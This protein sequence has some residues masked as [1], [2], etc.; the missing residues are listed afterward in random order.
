M[1]RPRQPILMSLILLLSTHAHAVTAKQPDAFP[2]PPLPITKDFRWGLMDRTGKVL[3]EPKYVRFGTPTEGL[4]WFTEKFEGPVGYMDYE[5]TIVIS[6]RYGMAHEFSDGYA[7][8]SDSGRP[9]ND[10][11]GVL[12][13]TYGVIDKTGAFVIEAKY[14][15][16]G[17]PFYKG[18][19]VVDALDRNYSQDVI[20]AQGR[21]HGTLQN[22][23][24]LRLTR[25]SEDFMPVKYFVV[26]A[27]RTG[28]ATRT[29]YG[30][31]D[32]RFRAV[33]VRFAK[34]RPFSDG[35]A[36]VQQANN[37]QWG[38][39]NKT[40]RYAIQ[41][42][43]DYATEFSEGVAAVSLSGD[44]GDPQ[45]GR[46]YQK[47]KWGYVDAKGRPAVAAPKGFRA[48]PFRGGVAPILLTNEGRGRDWDIYGD[49]IIINRVGETVFKL[50]HASMDP[51]EDGLALVRV[52]EK[53]F[54]C[55]VG[56]IDATGKWIREPV[57]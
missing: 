33:F 48:A 31:V 4:I 53:P 56:Y 52:Y 18:L 11:T 20:D 35:L 42:R 17:T 39:I 16:R 44:P 19:T 8:A 54:V 3:V 46:P 27:S 36:A 45:W 32:G 15:H 50:E 22:L 13:G 21:K 24:D 23:T 34:T 14:R 57:F 43:F 10:F 7:W 41:P 40:G 37:K 26:G 2:Q 55:K 30:F 49:V 38:Y 6:P 25:F 51:Y 47:V 29:Q 28:S 9:D 5:G 12:D 1:H